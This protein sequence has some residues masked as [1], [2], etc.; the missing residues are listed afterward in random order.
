MAPLVMSFVVALLNTAD[1]SKFKEFSYTL[2]SALWLIVTSGDEKFLQ[3]EAMDMVWKAFHQ[4]KLK[5]IKEWKLFL[6]SLQILTDGKHIHI[7]YQ[8]LLLDLVALIIKDRNTADSPP[9]NP[10]SDVVLSK[11]EEQV[12]RYAAG[13]VPFALCEKLRRQR[14]NTAAKFCKILSTWRVCS[15]NT[16]K[17]FLEYTNDWINVQNRGGLFHVKDDVYLLFRTM[18][19]EIRPILSKENLEKCAGQNIKSSLRETIL[20][21]HRVHDYWCNLTKDN[22]TGDS[23]RRLLDMVVN[24]WIK[25]RIKAF[26]K[27]YLDLKKATN[28]VSKKAEKALRKELAK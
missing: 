20:S 23:S 11:Q 3:P 6:A 14:N 15:T 21:K 22:I 17:T 26:L 10:S 12:L 8:H 1:T 16:A 24:L 5:S 7:V 19:N 18:E 9:Q 2:I 25:I 13:Y 4:Y 27:V 28:Q